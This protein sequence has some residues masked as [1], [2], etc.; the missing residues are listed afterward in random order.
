[1]KHTKERRRGGAEERGKAR[2]ARGGKERGRR[3]W[4]VQKKGRM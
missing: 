2:K 4:L 1:V 3:E